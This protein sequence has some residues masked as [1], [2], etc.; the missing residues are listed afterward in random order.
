MTVNANLLATLNI[1]THSATA[2]IKIGQ[3]YRYCH[4]AIM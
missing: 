3:S 4:R 2:E 1:L